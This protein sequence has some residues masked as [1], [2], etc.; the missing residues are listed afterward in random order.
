MGK[1]QVALG[2][3]VVIFVLFILYIFRCEIFKWDCPP[4]V[5]SPVQSPAEAP[6]KYCATQGGVSAIYTGGAGCVYTA[7]LKA[8]LKSEIDSGITAIDCSVTDNASACYV[9]EELSGSRSFPVVTC[10]DNETVYVGY[11]A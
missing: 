6:F 2:V 7:S 4:S 9:A 8:K 5:Q 3:G 1:Q 11:Q 10:K